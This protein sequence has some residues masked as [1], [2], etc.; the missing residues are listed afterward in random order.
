MVFVLCHLLHNLI[1]VFGYYDYKFLFP[2]KKKKL[3][4]GCI[5]S[6]EWK[7]FVNEHHEHFT[8]NITIYLEKAIIKKKITGSHFCLS[9]FPFIISDYFLIS[10]K[11]TKKKKNC[12]TSQQN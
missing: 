11:K 6:S 2:E 7:Y 12:P 4:T 3:S 8:M 9:Q 10:G 5:Q 1:L